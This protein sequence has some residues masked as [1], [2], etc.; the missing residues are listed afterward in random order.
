MHPV[1]MYTPQEAE[2]PPDGPKRPIGSFNLQFL[3][4]GDSWFT[5][6]RDGAVP[7]PS[8]RSRTV[9]LSRG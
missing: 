3:A 2:F 5:G 7:A 1:Q 9:Q 4:Q 8:G 6:N